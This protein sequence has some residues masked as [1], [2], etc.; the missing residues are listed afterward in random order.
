MIVPY[1]I[2][3]VHDASSEVILCLQFLVLHPGPY[4]PLRTIGAV[5]RAYERMEGRKK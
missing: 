4:Y 1:E 5:P 2:S 3:T